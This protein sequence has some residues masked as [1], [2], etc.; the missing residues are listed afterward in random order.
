MP[1]KKMDLKE[2]SVHLIVFER[3]ANVDYNLSDIK[4]FVIN[5]EKN[6]S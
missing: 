2:S 6:K 3:N 1:S 4:R 5:W